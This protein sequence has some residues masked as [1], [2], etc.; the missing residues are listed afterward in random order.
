MNKNFFSL[1]LILLMALPVHAQKAEKLT[2]GPIRLDR[3]QAKT[4]AIRLQPSSTYRLSARLKTESGTDIV[5]LQLVGLGANNI[6]L[7]SAKANWTPVEGTF[8]V[9]AHQTAAQVQVSFGQ[10]QTGL[11]GWADQITI[12]RT[13][14]YKEPR[15][16]GF[17]KRPKREVLSDMGVAMQP[18]NKIQWMRDAKLG[19]FIHWGLYAGP[20]QGEWYMENQGVPIEQYRKLAYPVAGPQQFDARDYDADQ[21]ATLA[22]EAG[23]RY[24]TLTTQHHDGFA[25][26]DSRYPN[27]FTAMQTLHR[28]LIKEFVEATRRAGLRVGFYKTLINWR[29]P[30]YY[31]ITGRDCRPNRFGYV[32]APWHK[33]N[34]QV[35]K[36][37]LYAQTRELLTHYGKIDQLFW[38]GGWIGQEGSDADGAPFW[39]SGQWLSADNAWPIDST[40]TM[41]DSVSGRRLGLMG[42]VRALQPDIVVNPRSGWRGDYTCEEGGADVKGPI[43]SGVV[44]KCMTISPA[45]GYT[46]ASEDIRR[47]A[48]LSKM[49]RL[50]ADCMVRGMC[51]LVNVGPDRHGRIPQAEQQRLREFGAW[52]K[53]NS[54]AI[55]ATQPG[56]WEPVDGQYGFTYKANKLYVYFL[57]GYSRPSLTLP[58]MDRGFKALR[59]YRL[60]NQTQAAVSQK[61]RV[62]TLSGLSLDNKDVTI[63]VVELNKDIDASRK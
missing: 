2:S 25:L 56:P 1:F 20:A 46:A 43:R 27:A 17:A 42:M 29:Y 48:S 13:G 9:A 44:E 4:I 22:K 18:D 51:F 6:T 35:M 39:E 14:D 26:F 52:V 53:A 28:D 47:L 3:G 7:S 50:C 59:A 36:E 11:H 54:P 38:D 10:D 16:K 24:I 58:P 40:Y 41:K 15:L 30:G 60:D 32:T 12:E 33:A 57:G 49:K 61:G 63:Y 21:W 8:H 34:A 23:F 55:Y 31:D 37:E 45:W 62:A 19:L 5:A